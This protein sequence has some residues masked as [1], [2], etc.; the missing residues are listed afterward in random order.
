MTNF[1]SEY[2]NSSFTVIYSF[3]KTVIWG[4]NFSINTLFEVNQLNGLDEYIGSYGLVASVSGPNG[5]VAMGR[6]MGGATTNG[7]L[8]YAGSHWGPMNVTAPLSRLAFGNPTLQNFTAGVSIQFIVEIQLA[9]SVNGLGGV[10]TE[11][12]TTYAGSINIID[13]TSNPGFNFGYLLI[14]ALAAAIAIVAVFLFSSSRRKSR[15]GKMTANSTTKISRREYFR[16]RSDKWLNAL[17]D[18]SL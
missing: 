4:T 5:Y 7:I 9:N 3:P 11:T 15:A 16:S 13:S 2:G 12:N 1:R 17:R 10:E 18:K 6:V 14:G 8:L